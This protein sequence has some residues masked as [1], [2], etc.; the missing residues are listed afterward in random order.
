[1]GGTTVLDSLTSTSTSSALSANMGRELNEKIE[2]LDTRITTLENNSGDSAAQCDC[3]L[4]I[5]T[6]SVA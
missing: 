1:M 6:E 5:W 3:E 4:R 2:A